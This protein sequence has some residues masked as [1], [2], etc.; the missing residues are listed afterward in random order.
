MAAVFETDFA[1]DDRLAGGLAVAEPE[2]HGLAVEMLGFAMGDVRKVDSGGR[3][4][5][6]P[7]SVVR[8][9]VAR[10]PYERCLRAYCDQPRPTR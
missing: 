2:Q 9:E 3:E 1:V 10:P 4:G 7:G 5:G 6:S 8:R